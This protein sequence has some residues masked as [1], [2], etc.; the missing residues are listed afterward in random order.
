MKSINEKNNISWLNIH[1]QGMK[2][3]KSGVQHKYDTRPGGAKVWRENLVFDKLHFTMNNKLK[4]I[5][6]MQNTFS[7]KES[8]S[9]EK[10]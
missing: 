5:K 9:G 4:L 2:I 7:V 8:K 10:I 3:L 6:Y 1:L